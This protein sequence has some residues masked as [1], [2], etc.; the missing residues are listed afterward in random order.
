MIKFIQCIRK[1]P[2]LSHVEFRRLWAEYKDRAAAVAE[3]TGVTRFS[4]STAL[5]VATNV[6]VQLERG[7]V[8]AFDGVAEFWFPK[9]AGLEGIFERPEVI[10]RVSAMREMQEQMADLSQSVFFF[11]SEEVVSG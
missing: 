9:A 10:K 5:T 3:V 7:T 11:V 1:K 6:H 4:V 2:E 8:A